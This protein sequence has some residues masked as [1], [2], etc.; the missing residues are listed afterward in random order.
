MWATNGVMIQQLGDSQTGLNVECSGHSWLQLFAVMM[1]KNTRSRESQVPNLSSNFSSTS[2]M[3]IPTVS[4][5]LLA[6]SNVITRQVF[7]PKSQ[8]TA[9]KL[10]KVSSQ[11]HSTKQS[12]VPGDCCQRTGWRRKT[13]TSKEREYMCRR[14]RRRRKCFKMK[15]NKK[16]ISQRTFFSFLVV[17]HVVTFR[18]DSLQLISTY[19]V[20]LCLKSKDLWAKTFRFF[21]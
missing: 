8:A 6:S 13:S 1:A 2:C 5:F 20:A 11:K 4:N 18:L 17:R 16:K 14:R 7:H 19:C 10:K 3:M 15:I 21:L 9:T 12:K